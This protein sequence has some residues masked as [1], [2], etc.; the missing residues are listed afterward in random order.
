M[1][2]FNEDSDS[3]LEVEERDE[4]LRILFKQKSWDLDSSFLYKWKWAKLYE[5]ASTD[6]KY[7]FIRIEI[8]CIEELKKDPK[9]KD[10][11]LHTD[12]IT[13]VWSWDGQKAIHLL[14]WTW[15]S[16][17]YIAED[18]S[19]DMLKAVK[20]NILKKKVKINLGNFQV[21]NSQRHLSSNCSNNMYLFLWGT[22]GNMSDEQII[23][24]LR[25]MD[26]HGIINW[27]KI[28]L[29]YFTAPETQEE[30]DKL[31]EIYGSEKDRA[32]HENALDMLWLSRDDFEYDVIYE[33]DNPSQKEWPFPW[34]IKWIIRAKRDCIVKLSNWKTIAIKK[35]DCFTLHYSRRFTKE[36]IQS[37]FEKSG[38]NVL[39]TIDKGWD[40][41]ALLKRRPGKLKKV[42]KI[43]RNTLIWALLSGIATIGISH[44]CDN[45]KQKEREKE[46]TEWESQHTTWTEWII[47]YPEDINE[48][49]SALQLNKLNN[50]DKNFVIDLYMEYISDHK[51]DSTSNEELI[52]WFWQ[53]YWWILI[54]HFWISRPYNFMTQETINNTKNIWVELS[55]T[56][57]YISK[58]AVQSNYRYN[59][60]WKFKTI[61]KDIPFEYNDWWEIYT[62]V[63][64][65]ISIWWE[66]KWVYFASKH[67]KKWDTY[68]WTTFSTNKINEINDKSWLD[69][70]TLSNT[71][72][73]WQSIIIDIG[74]TVF[75]TS[76]QINVSYEDQNQV[77]KMCELN[78]KWIS[79]YAVYLWNWEIY[80]IITVTTQ[81][82][83]QIWLA[84]KTI[85]WTYT[86]TTFNEIS[87]QFINAR[88]L[89]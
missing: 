85:D 77:V 62:I 65:K 87:E 51:N 11:L 1:E 52:Q 19:E 20:K 89:L 63:K 55:Y 79:P 73:L 42:K 53:E 33:K 38:C 57:S 7:P 14:E 18:P 74:N 36:W 84:S 24:E 86:T 78:D 22:I 83:W 58:N 25:N 39:F 28:L 60:Y 54:K 5:E 34:K 40:S 46:Y 71:Q 88:F 47:C 29:S 26:N 15:W 43:V 48:L 49:I 76:N 27:N 68:L 21:I 56:P 67:I 80:Y 6:D 10:I 3:T 23:E 45:K 82:W 30:I 50:K 59:D 35:W 44:Y 64:V 2:T 70:E 31:L 12:Y 72:W 9:F 41:V 17:K 69:S 4:I 13:D 16:G 61:C 8:Q 75:W 66:E 81:S 37:L 32:F